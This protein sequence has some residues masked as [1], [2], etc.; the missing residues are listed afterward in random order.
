MALTTIPGFNG[1][2]YARISSMDKRAIG[3]LTDAN[4]LESLHSSDPADYD[5]K[6]ISIYTQSSLYAN[7]FI[8]MLNGSTPFFI[9]GNTDSWKWDIEIPYRFPKIIAIPSATEALAKPGIDGQEFQ[10]ILDREEFFIHHIV[11]PHKQF[12]SQWYILRDPEPVN[13]GYLYTATLLSNNPKVEFVEKKFLQHG[14]ELQLVNM[15]VGEF[16]QELP[17]LPGP[18]DKHTMY[19]SLGSAIGYEHKITAWADDKML[20]DSNGRPLDLLVYMDRR[21]NETPVTRS[22]IKWEPYVEFLLRKAM[23]DLKVEKMIW[24][25]PGAP[26]SRGSKQE[27][28][29][30]SA[31]VYH[32]MKNNGNY[33]SYP[34][35]GFSSTIF[36]T[37]FGDLFYRRVDVS[38]RKVKIFTNEAGFEVFS[39]SLKTEAFNSGFTFN[40]GDNNKFIRGSGQNL[41]L[42]YAFNSMVTR[43]T[44]EITLV[45]LKELDLPQTQLEYGQNLKSTPIFMVFDVSPDGDGTLKNNLREVRLEGMPSMTW[46]YIDGRRHHLG[47]AASHGHSAGNKFPG[48][49]IFFDDRYDVFIEDLS[50]CV[51]IEETPAY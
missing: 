20:R 11:T 21:R 35:G 30:V 14:I 6:I 31:G 28:K 4:H 34:K 48:Y 51:L 15:S 22:S 37:I 50:R 13:T 26:K 7:D 42:D 47:F 12:G 16:D 46:G 9:R 38:R 25:K 33:L 23:M 40:V 10:F 44:G 5:K 36:R 3:K 29:K 43:E 39:T 8:D 18:A 19:E 45:H 32:R 49:E 41:V 1:F 2:S 27:V 17:G 24:G